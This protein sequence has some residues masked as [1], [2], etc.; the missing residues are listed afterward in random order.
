MTPGDK[1]VYDL[2]VRV[3]NDVYLGRFADP[4]GGAIYFDAWRS[5]SSL[6]VRAMDI[7]FGRVRYI[8]TIGAHNF[9]GKP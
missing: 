4:T 9:Y 2:A 1:S 6:E 5:R 3:A 8:T 7:A